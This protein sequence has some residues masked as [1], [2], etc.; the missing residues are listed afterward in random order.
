MDRNEA[1]TELARRL[2]ANVNFGEKTVGLYVETALDEDGD[3]LDVGE[4]TYLGEKW[5]YVLHAS[6]LDLFRVL[7]VESA[8][9]PTVE[10]ERRTLP[11]LRGGTCTEQIWTHP[12]E[13]W[14]S[15][16]MTHGS[17]DDGEPL[18]IDS[19]KTKGSFT[20]IVAVLR[21]WARMSQATIPAT[22][23]PSD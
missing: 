7:K 23:R 5:V 8:E 4:I 20:E 21:G 15:I 6:G 3:P 10:F 12:R 18:M 22:E 1:R 16:T 19:K 9:A 2:S 11:P 13:T 17:L 14:G